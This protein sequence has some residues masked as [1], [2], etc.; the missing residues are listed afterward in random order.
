M[1]NFQNSNQY[2][3]LMMKDKKKHI[4]IISLFAQ[5]KNF[6]FE[7]EEQIQRF[8]KRHTRAA[9]E[10]DCYSLTKIKERMVYLDETVDYKWTLE[11]ILKFIDENITTLK[12]EQ[13]IIILKNGDKIYDT[14]HLKDLEQQ[15]R[16]FWKDNKWIEQD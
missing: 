3:Q 8:I 7:N 6:H 14:K 5:V 12:G 1:S 11:T 4:P 2:L 9:K 15:G 10:L 16:I 13:P